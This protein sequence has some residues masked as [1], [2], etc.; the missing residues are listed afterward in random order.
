MDVH[1]LHV[2]AFISGSAFLVL[3]VPR[4]LGSHNVSRLLGVYGLINH[5]LQRLSARNPGA[6][7]SHLT[8]LPYWRE[9]G[10]RILFSAPRRISRS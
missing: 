6:T 8:L 5:L 7:L 9:M 10:T 1:D 2:F 3:G 4:L